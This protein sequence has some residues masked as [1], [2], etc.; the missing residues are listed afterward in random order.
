MLCTFVY[1]QVWPERPAAC[2]SARGL[3]LTSLG[4]ESVPLRSGEQPERNPPG[5]GAASLGFSLGGNSPERW[6]VMFGI[7]AGCGPCEL[8]RMRVRMRAAPCGASASCARHVAAPLCV[9]DAK[10]RRGGGGGSDAAPSRSSPTIDCR[11]DHPQA[12]RGLISR[13]VLKCG[14]LTA[15]STSS[16][17]R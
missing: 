15:G 10:T 2:A 12:K 13:R 17:V 14:R 7:L 4:R 11:H 8:T 5:S 3:L 9:C 6:E 1:V 16:L